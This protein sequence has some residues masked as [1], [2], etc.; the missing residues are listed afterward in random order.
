MQKILRASNVITSI[1][2]FTINSSVPAGQTADDTNQFDRR[3]SGLSLKFDDDTEEQ[4]GETEHHTARQETYRLEEG[5]LVQEVHSHYPTSLLLKKKNRYQSEIFNMT[6]MYDLSFVTNKERRLGP[7]TESDLPLGDG[8]TMKIPNKIRHLEKNCPG[9]FSWL[10]GFGCEMVK[11]PE[12]TAEKISFFPIWGFKAHFKVYPVKQQEFDFVSGFK[13]HYQFSL[14]GLADNPS[15]ESLEDLNQI[16]RSPVH[17]VV[18]LEDSESEPEST[19]KRKSSRVDD[20]NEDSIMVVDSEDDDDEDNNEEEE[21]EEEEEDDGDG[22]Q[23]G[24]I[25]QGYQPSFR[26]NLNNKTGGGEDEPIEIE[27]SS[28]EEKE[29]ETAE[30]GDMKEDNGDESSSFPPE[31]NNKRKR[32]GS[33]ESKDGSEEAFKKSKDDNDD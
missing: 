3:V 29:A 27:S 11:L 21:E 2:V 19:N 26:G 8:L 33:S 20:Q 15:I 25:P 24:M 13:K 31:E 12:T 32:E 30:D 1:T 7:M 5:E 14:N 16:E 4:L 23:H 6:N 28:E 18:D 9:S 10:Q 22:F 17:E